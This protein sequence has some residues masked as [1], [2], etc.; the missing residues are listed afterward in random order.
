ME[1]YLGTI[2]PF[3][4]GFTPRGWAVCNGQL[5]AISQNEALF[6]LLG[7]MYGGDGRTTFGLPDLRGYAPVGQGTGPGLT[8]RKVGQKGGSETNTLNSNQLAGHTHGID[9]FN[10]NVNANVNVPTVNDDGGLEE[11]E[12]NI[13]ANHPGGYA[14]ATAKDGA[15]GQFNAPI[16]GAAQTGNTGNSQSINN[17]QP[18]L[19]VNYCICTEGV[20]PSRN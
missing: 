2:Q 5:L 14:A 8:N 7:T 4:F 18:Y 10:P 3:G 1:E 20:Y 15:L 12:G 19:T 13:L 11:S 6:S 16:S 17:M 9:M